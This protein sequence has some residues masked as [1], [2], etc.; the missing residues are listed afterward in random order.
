MLLGVVVI[1]A[2]RVTECAP[3]FQTGGL[4][5]QMSPLAERDAKRCS[6]CAGIGHNGAVRGIICI[7]GLMG[8]AFRRRDL[9]WCM[10]IDQNL[11]FLVA[12]AVK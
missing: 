6:I 9:S 2:G 5:I 3:G 8:G 12:R 10:G 11:K 1:V 4:P 7:K